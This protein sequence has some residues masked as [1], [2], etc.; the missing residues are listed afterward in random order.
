VIVSADAPAWV[1]RETG[2]S[3]QMVDSLPDPNMKL[4]QPLSDAHL[5]ADSRVLLAFP[6]HDV[7]AWLSPANQYEAKLYGS[8]AYGGSGES[9][10][11][12]R[13][14]AVS[15]VAIY[16]MEGNQKVIAHF[17]LSLQLDGIFQPNI[18]GT[19]DTVLFP[20]PDGNWLMTSIRKPTLFFKLSQQNQMLVHYSIPSRA[21]GPKANMPQLTPYEDG[22]LVGIRAGG[23]NAFHCDPSGRIIRQFDFDFN[24]V[25]L[26]NSNFDAGWRGLAAA[27]ISPTY[28]FLFKDTEANK[29]YL[30]R[31]TP[32]GEVMN[33]S[34][35][36]FPA[37]GFSVQAKEILLFESK[38]GKA[39]MYQVN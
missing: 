33:F 23:H 20:A 29:S 22:T 28:F 21:G 39:Q 9:V 11:Q 32:K 4:F 27:F 10:N 16:L 31:T 26:H 35:V 38:T 13:K 8:V 34:E 7:V 37:D 15:N 5:T 25:N 36:P 18:R 12:T 19:E 3:F 17:D 24:G 1:W 14:M 2:L 30:L 6:D